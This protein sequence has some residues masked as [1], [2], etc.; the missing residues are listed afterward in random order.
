MLMRAADPLRFPKIVAPL[1]AGGLAVGLVFLMV[2]LW[3]AVSGSNRVTRVQPP[4]YERLSASEKLDRALTLPGFQGALLGTVGQP[5][6]TFLPA[7]G[8]PL[9]R[10]VTEFPFL[11]AGFY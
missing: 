6:V 4:G 7:P 11:V 5:Y 1:V 10:A 8:F 3:G 9:G 2:V